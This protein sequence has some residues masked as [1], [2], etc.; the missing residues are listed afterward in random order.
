[1]SKRGRV[2]EG[3]GRVQEVGG[4]LERRGRGREGGGG[5]MGSGERMKRE[6]LI[7]KITKLYYF[8]QIQTLD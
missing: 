2:G 8:T 5:E 3:R 6:K 4:G 7:I 1:M